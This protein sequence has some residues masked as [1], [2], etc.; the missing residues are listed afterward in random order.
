MT[1]PC[2]FFL[3][4]NFDFSPWNIWPK[5]NPVSIPSVSKVI[6]GFETPALGH[7]HHSSWF[8]PPTERGPFFVMIVRT[9][10]NTSAAALE[11]ELSLESVLKRKRELCLHS[12]QLRISIICRCD[13]DNIGTNEVN[14]IKATDN[15]SQLTSRPTASLGGTS[16]RRDYFNSSVAVCGSNK[17]TH[18]G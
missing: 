16:C 9:S 13:L 4:L 3:Q 14:S 12:S 5:L 15:G 11:M 6:D 2:S 1:P 17:P 18:L 8:V 10:N 7:S